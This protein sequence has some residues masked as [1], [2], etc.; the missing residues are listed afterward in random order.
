MIW[1][2]ISSF[3]MAFLRRI[4]VGQFRRIERIRIFRDG[5]CVDFL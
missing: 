3:S 4:V 5:L 1:G 2:I